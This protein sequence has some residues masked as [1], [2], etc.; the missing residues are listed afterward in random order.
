MCST[1]HRAKGLE[2]SRVY[3]LADT[4]YCSGKRDTEEERNIHYVGVT[5]AKETLVLVSEKLD[6]VMI[7]PAKPP[8]LPAARR[9]PR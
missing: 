3:L 9:S 5:R 8:R 6:G 7:Y 2:A 1:I 4:L